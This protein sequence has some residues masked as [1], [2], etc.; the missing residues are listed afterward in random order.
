MVY[1]DYICETCGFT[2]Q[3]QRGVYKCPVCGTQMKVHHADR[4]GGGLPVGAGRLLIYFLL[5]VTVLPVCIGFLGVIGV[6]VFILVFI[7]VRHFLKKRTTNQA[8]KTTPG[9]TT[10]KNPNKVYTC[11]TCGG[12]FKGQQPVCPHCGIRLRY[13]E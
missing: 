7:L 4:H 8:V 13:N 12:N 6:P 3:E 10:V 1:E 5:C 11:N 2:S 9:V